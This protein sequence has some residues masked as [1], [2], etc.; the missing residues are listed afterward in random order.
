MPD[1]GPATLNLT[2]TMEQG[3]PG[4][5]NDPRN[6]IS[7]ALTS[8]MKDSSLL[9]TFTQA[10][11]IDETA[12]EPW[13]WL[14]IF[15]GSA[16]ERILFFPGFK[17]QIT[18]V[19]GSRGE[20]LHFDRQ[21]RLDHVSLEKHR[22][23]WHITTA[24][25]KDH[26]GGPEATDLGDGRVLWFGLSLASPEVLR[27]LRQETVATFE[28]P[29]RTAQWKADQFKKSREG[30]EFPGVYLPERPDAARGPIFPLISVI[31]GP[32]GFEP[33]RGPLWGWP[34][35]SEFTRGEPKGD[36]AIPSWHQRFKLD[37][38]TDIQLTAIWAPGEL[39]IPAVMS[40]PINPKA[41]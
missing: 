30:K 34:Y 24:R 9:P 14:G 38:K 13:R 7:R 32:T 39:T 16:G 19:R 1:N 17:E 6:P 40:A 8:L 20:S 10:F 12:A 35:G 2:F 22:D 27:E 5:D 28:V 23:T 29:D 33:Y 25:S 4:T 36:W 26:Q 41:G 15:V 31:V 3:A 18:R 21:F 37:E 11:L